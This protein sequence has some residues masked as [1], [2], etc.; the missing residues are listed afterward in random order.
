MIRLRASAL[1]LLCSAAVL[2]LFLTVIMLFW[3]PSPY[4]Q[5]DGGWTVLRILILVDLVLGPL[6][7]LIVYQPGKPSLRFD[8]SCIVLMQVGALLY[9]GLTIYQG[10]PEFV[11][12]AVDRFTTVAPAEIEG[13]L[14]KLRYPDLAEEAIRGP[15]L[16]VA[17]LP[18]DTEKRHSILFSA[19]AGGRDVEHMPEY[20]E[21]YPPDL[22]ELR[23]R[24]L[25]LADYA[26]ADPGVKAAL[27]AFIE[28]R[29]GVPDDYLFLPLVG[30]N[31]D[32]VMVLSSGDGR[33]VGAIGIDP[34]QLRKIAG[35]QPA[36]GGSSAG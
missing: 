26:L 18:D 23:A 15:R 21:P 14:D 10:R 35:S 13:E 31:R 17:R 4:F 9:G 6:L 19:A 12:F 32:M 7:T 27:D 25:A 34:W 22:Q 30:K 33:P 8:M 11:V 2:S 1:H 16:V 29:G 36:A 28:D 5:A 3:Y 20:Y 24:S